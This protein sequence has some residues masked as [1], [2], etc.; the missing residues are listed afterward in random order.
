MQIVTW[1]LEQTILEAIG[2]QSIYGGHTVESLLMELRDRE[3]LL[4]GAPKNWTQWSEAE[5]RNSVGHMLQ[6]Q[7]IDMNSQG[8][9]LVEERQDEPLQHF[10]G[11]WFVILNGTIKGPLSEGEAKCL[12]KK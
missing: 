8:V 7:K 5:V 11:A 4:W 6:T 2:W 12:L 1:D 9:L 3:L 10:A